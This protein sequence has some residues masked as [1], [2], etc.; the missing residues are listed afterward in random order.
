MSPAPLSIPEPR[1]TTSA[2]GTS[3]AYYVVGDGPLT[4]V[5]PPAMGAPLIS[6]LR[7]Y[8]ALS[9]EVRVITWDMRGFQ[10]SGAPADPDALDIPRNADDLEAVVQAEGLDRF[11][12]GGWS[13]AVPISLEYARRRPERPL[14]LLLI[15]GPIESALS[16]AMPHPLLAR[17]MVGAIDRVGDRV[18]R[19]ANPWSVR[20]FGAKGI[21]KLVHRLGVITQEP[22]YFE[23]ILEEF[24]HIDWARYFRVMRWLHQYDATPFLHEVRQPTL[25]VTGTRD[26]M[27]PVSTAFRLADHLPHA[28]VFVVQGGTHYTPAEFSGE[29]AGR[30]RAFLARHVATAGMATPREVSAGR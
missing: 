28:E 21:G 7:L 2:D 20:I 12:L 13:M 17:A 25:I 9:R 26:I 27:T 6:M 24:R 22:E 15:N 18:G 16:H 19:I 30:I 11:V 1:F 3:L 4:W 10:R 8:T 14:A 23:S 5:A 29:L